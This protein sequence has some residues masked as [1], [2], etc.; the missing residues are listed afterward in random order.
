VHTNTEITGIIGITSE[1]RNIQS[2]CRQNSKKCYGWGFNSL[3]LIRF[4]CDSY[5][6]AYV[7]YCILRYSDVI[8]LIPVIYVIPV[9][10]CTRCHG[11]RLSVFMQ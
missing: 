7:V 1:Y 6:F 10:E 5:V 11:M 9:F 4:T 3:I 2:F 8:P